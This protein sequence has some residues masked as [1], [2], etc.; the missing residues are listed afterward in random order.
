M[1]AAQCASLRAPMLH[2]ACRVDG[3]ELAVECVDVSS[4]HLLDRADGSQRAHRCAEE[5]DAGEEEE[6][7]LFGGGWHTAMLMAPA[8]HRVSEFLPPGPNRNRDVDVAIPTRQ[9]LL[10]R[11]APNASRALRQHH[12]L[13]EGSAPRHWPR[14]PASY[15]ANC[16][17][18][19]R[20]RSLPYSS[21]CR[22]RRSHA[23]HA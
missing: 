23:V 2:A 22:S 5:D 20:S 13:S 21:R 10:Q 11:P 18:C 19:Q 4:W 12:P 17:V 15:G 1:P 7:L 3:G 6:G 16:A 9:E 8:A 14:R